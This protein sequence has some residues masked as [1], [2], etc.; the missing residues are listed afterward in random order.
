MSKL[1]PYH[2]LSGKPLPTSQIPAGKKPSRYTRAELDAYHNTQQSKGIPTK[3]ISAPTKTYKPVIPVKA[4]SFKTGTPTSAD[5]LPLLQAFA[6]PVTD[7]PYD[8]MS[9]H[10]TLPNIFQSLPVHVL[11]DTGAIQANFVSVRAGTWIRGH[12]DGDSLRQWKKDDKATYCVPRA[13]GGP[14]HS[15]MH[16]VDK[17]WNEGMPATLA[18]NGTS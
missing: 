2:D 5:I 16:V 1:S 11:F 12:A 15:R 18:V 6:L 17:L 7:K 14:T 9:C 13:D 10:L 8:T 4:T 3:S